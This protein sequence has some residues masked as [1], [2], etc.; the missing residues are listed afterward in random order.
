[1]VTAGTCRFRRGRGQDWLQLG[2]G[3]HN[4]PCC[5][6]LQRNMLRGRNTAWRRDD[7]RHYDR[8]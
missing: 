5:M 3:E 6:A 2:P 4:E 8:S 1:M 7:P